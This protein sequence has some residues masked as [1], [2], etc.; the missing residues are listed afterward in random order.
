MERGQADVVA[1]DEI[2][3]GDAVA[4]WRSLDSTGR[5]QRVA[6]RRRERLV[7][8]VAEATVGPQRR[9][10]IAGALEQTGF[11]DLPGRFPPDGVTVEG[12]IVVVAARMGTRAHRVV[13]RP[14]EAL[15]SALARVVHLL[16]DAATD[17]QVRSPARRYWRAERLEAGRA[18]RVRRRG[19]LP[20]LPIDR[21]PPLPSS[22]LRAV[23]AP[24]EWVPVDAADEE[25]SDELARE[26]RELVLGGP[27]SSWLVELWQGQPGGT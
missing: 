25:R 7:L 20:H 16:A 22:V 27:T 6:Y 26:P 18:E 4:V 11:F 9:F 21:G 10:A 15:P 19:L 17:E 24:G 14:P 23:D 5:W 1:V 13:A 8:S 3:R 2:P 12:D